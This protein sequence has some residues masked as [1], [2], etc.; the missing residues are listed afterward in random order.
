M[1]KDKRQKRDMHAL[2]AEGTYSSGPCPG[3]LVL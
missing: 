2:D 1:P 3:I